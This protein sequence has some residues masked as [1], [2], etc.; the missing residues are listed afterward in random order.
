M[1]PSSISRMVFVFRFHLIAVLLVGVL[2][3]SGCTPAA[4]DA[5]PN[6]VLILADDLGYGDLG[7]YNPDSKIPTPHLDRL[8]AEGIRFTD[9]HS[10]SAVCTPT[11]YG[12]LTGRYSWRTSLTSG[13]LWGYSPLLIDTSRVTL[14]SLLQTRGYATAGVGKWHLGLGAAEPTDYTQP[15]R[16]G[17]LDVGFDQYFGIPASLDM[18]PYVYIENGRVEALPTDSI[19]PSEM[20][21]H[22]G[23]GFWRGGPIAPDFRHIDVLPRFTEEAVAYLEE[24]AIAPETPFFLYLPLSAPHT[25]WL[26]TPAFEGRSGAGPYGD[27]AAQ[28][29][30]T[31]GAVLAS[32]DR[33][34]LAETTLLIV[35]SDNGAH[36]LPDDIAQYD[37]RA[38]GPWRG[39]KADIHE[40]G[41]RVPFLA[42]WPGRIPAGAVSD[43]VLSQTDLLATLA[44]AVGTEVPDGAGEDSYNLLPALLGE[45]PATPSRDAIVHHSLDGMFAIRQGPWKLIEGRGSGGFTPPRRIEPA[46]GEPAGQLYNL[47]DDPAETTNRYA[48]H[49]EIVER[50][51]TLLDQI[52]DQGTSRPV[53]V[54]P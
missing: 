1:I 4:E 13:V 15:L 48:E 5:P 51:Q 39:Q 44:A 36:W 42:R 35:T 54:H 25:P 21:R 16:P 33:L 34:G 37:H 12:L 7:S 10:P 52:R 29:D 32:L 14:P 53:A 45:A 50:L 24:R 43:A 47:A 22:G 30:S 11:R 19:G 31:V 17:P 38:N 40:G 28:V 26:P 6:I 27:F 23:G 9:A 18:V 41:H 8:A 2:L 3:S 49:P 20:R 46:P